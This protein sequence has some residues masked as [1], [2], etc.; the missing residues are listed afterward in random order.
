MRYLI[1]CLICSALTGCA[2]PKWLENRVVCTADRAEAHVLSKWGPA[3]IGAQVADAD[4]R[5]ICRPTP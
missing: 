4:A 5:V 1:G 3:S 2:G